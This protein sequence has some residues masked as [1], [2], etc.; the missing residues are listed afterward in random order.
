MKRTLTDLRRRAWDQT[1]NLEETELAPGTAGIGSMVPMFQCETGF[2]ITVVGLRRG[3]LN[4]GLSCDQKTEVTG[5]IQ[6]F[7]GWECRD[8]RDCGATIQLRW[9]KHLAWMLLCAGRLNMAPMN[10]PWMLQPDWL[11][12]RL[13]Y[14]KLIKMHMWL[15]TQTAI[16]LT[17]L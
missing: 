8:L 5:R 12:I 11:V 15:Q 16:C 3:G 10:P 6:I 7:V 14:F 17:V 4:V 1:K 13:N 2:R 9:W